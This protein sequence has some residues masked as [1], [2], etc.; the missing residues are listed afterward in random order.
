VV[1]LAR[2]ESVYT[3]TGIEGSNPSFSANPIPGKARD[4]LYPQVSGLPERPEDVKIRFASGERDWVEA[5]ILTGSTQ[6]IPSF[7]S[8]LW[9]TGLG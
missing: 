9:R 6:L 7:E 4:F 8:R 5:S 3:L 1:E 2:L